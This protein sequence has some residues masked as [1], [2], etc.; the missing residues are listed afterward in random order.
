MGA[1]LKM[2]MQFN[3]RAAIL[4]LSL[5]LQQSNN[6]FHEY[7]HQLT[8]NNKYHPLGIDQEPKS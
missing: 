1:Y 4:K 3:K 7:S 2:F 6:A 5:L 8:V